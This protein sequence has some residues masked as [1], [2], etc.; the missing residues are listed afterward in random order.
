MI[1]MQDTFYFDD[2]NFGKLN[3]TKFAHD[4]TAVLSWH[5]QKFGSDL[6]TEN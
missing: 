6:I 2:S 5:V 1:Q 4:M 3:I